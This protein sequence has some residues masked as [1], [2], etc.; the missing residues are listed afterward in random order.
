MVKKAEWK[1]GVG[2]YLDNSALVSLSPKPHRVFYDLSVEWM[3]E[4]PFKKPE[5]LH[6]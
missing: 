5:I 2:R 4:K 6:V 3:L 1:N